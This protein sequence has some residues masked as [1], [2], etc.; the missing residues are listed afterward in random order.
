MDHAVVRVVRT[1]KPPAV[2]GQRQMQPVHAAFPE[3]PQHLVNPLVGQIPDEGPNGPGWQM[4]IRKA[5]NN[6]SATTESKINLFA[7]EIIVDVWEENWKKKG[8]ATVVVLY[9]LGRAVQVRFF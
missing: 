4:K 8:D 3:A 5:H 1:V 6:T 2:T 7:T 9:T